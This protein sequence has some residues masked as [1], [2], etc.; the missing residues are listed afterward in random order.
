MPVAAWRLT[1]AVG[2]A[3]CLLLSSMDAARS[4]D[5]EAPA[6]DVSAP[7]EAIETAFQ[8]VVTAASTGDWQAADA[9]FNG[10]LDAMDVHVP[11]IVDALGEPA[12]SVFS[13]LDQLIGPLVAALDGE[14]LPRVRATVALI[15]QELN[16]LSPA[17]SGPSPSTAETQAVLRW[18][19]AVRQVV[20]LG[21]QGA[22][23]DMRNV[24]MALTDTVNREGADVV[25]ATGPDAQVSVDT[26]RVFAMRL[27]AAAQNQSPAAARAAADTV[28]GALEEILVALG[29]LPPQAV[30]TD[31]QVRMRFRAHHVT[32]DPGDVVA[33]PF[34]VEAVPRIGLGSFDLELGWSPKAL[35]LV[36]SSWTT[37][38]GTSFRDDA[39]GKVRLSLPPAPTGP[40]GDVDLLQ[41]RFEVL[42]DRPLAEDYLPAGETAAVERAVA[43]A[44]RLVREGDVPNAA[45]EL[46]QAYLSFVGGEGQAGS[47]HDRLA[48]YGLADPLAASLLLAL[49]VASRPAEADVILLALSELDSRASG[50]WEAYLQSMGGDRGVPISVDVLAVTDTTG[51][52]LETLDPEPGLVLRAEALLPAPTATRDVS[53]V[54]E[55]TFRP[56]AAAGDATAANRTGT[57]DRRLVETSTS[58]GGGDAVAMVTGVAV[59]PDGSDGGPTMADSDDA[60]QGGGTFPVAFVVAMLVAVG[61]GLIVVVMGGD[62]EPEAVADAETETETADGA[63]ADAEDDLADGTEA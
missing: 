63:E 12:V 53:P 37:S 62:D 19:D 47:L 21:E 4:Q 20:A 10:A 34:G 22:W 16:A 31:E 25:A 30:S 6:P 11:A 44:R 54:A 45:T 51:D 33:V 32:G 27:I 40:S 8:A 9:A 55:G 14:D 58:D 1:I 5:V 48:R 13:R 39:A 38:P 24:A 61:A 2:V 49:D 26:A 57:P 59:D 60:A 29:A 41:L 56:S 3:L 43:E 52:A 7:V 18:Q 46:E 35:R 23:R 50:T 28:N 17:A 15:R 42:A 36:D